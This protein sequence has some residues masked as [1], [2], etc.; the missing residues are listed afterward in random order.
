MGGVGMK[1]KKKK[2]QTKERFLVI[3][4]KA[5]ESAGSSH[6]IHAVALLLVCS[7]CKNVCVFFILFY[8]F[9][10]GAKF[11]ESTVRPSS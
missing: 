7:M 3:A 9:F 11:L 8:Y 1:I 10:Q 4:E 6:V 2:I 5:E